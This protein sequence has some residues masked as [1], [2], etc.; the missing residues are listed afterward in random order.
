MWNSPEHLGLEV[1]QLYTQI[2]H[3]SVDAAGQAWWVNYLMQG[4]GEN[5]MEAA[6]LASSEYTAAH[7]TSASFLQGLYADVLGRASDAAGFAAWLQ[8]LQGG[9][10]RALVAQAFLN[11][12]EAIGNV[13]NRDYTQF[14]LRL[15]GTAER[16]AWV[17]AEQN[18]GLSLEQVGQGI[19]ASDE[20]FALP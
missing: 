9:A 6:L 19:L 3:R 10:N 15:A 13:V 16:N 4:H 5:D 7:S 14:L 18:G 17:A 2:L 11:S 1:N 12:S 20:F 8:A